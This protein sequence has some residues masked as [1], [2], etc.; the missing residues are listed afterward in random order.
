MVGATNYKELLSGG[1]DESRYT[2]TSYAFNVAMGIIF[3]YQVTG[4]T[5]I[6]SAGIPYFSLSLSLNV[7]LTLMI[8]VRLTLHAR[9]V[10]TATGETGSGG[11]CTAIVTIFVESCPVNA[12][13]SVLVLG[14]LGDGNDPMD[15]LLPI[16]PRTRVRAFP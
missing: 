9:D 8:V 3:V 15:I 13:T 1:S 4:P 16:L 10:R 12:V 5:T 2:G 7:I 6:A 11:L 14:L